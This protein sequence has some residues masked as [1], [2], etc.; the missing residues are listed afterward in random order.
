MKL[1]KSS[2]KKVGENLGVVT[3]LSSI[4]TMINWGIVIFAIRANITALFQCHQL[5]MH[6]T[7]GT[8]PEPYDQNVQHTGWL[9]WPCYT[10]GD[11]FDDEPHALLETIITVKFCNESRA[12]S[13]DKL[14]TTGN[15]QQWWR[16][17]SKQWFRGGNRTAKYFNT[18]LLLP[19]P[20][21]VV[22]S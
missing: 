7:F 4:R 12:V 18:G 14:D 20:W 3:G 16:T 17:R 21:I 22:A 11:C 10:T 13:G 8:T 1:N 2:L 6:A 19:F 9:S 5:Y 15:R